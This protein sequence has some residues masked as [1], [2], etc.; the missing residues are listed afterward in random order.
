MEK[1]VGFNS[2][3]YEIVHKYVH[4]HDKLKVFNKVCPKRRNVP[5]KC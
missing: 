2:E 4:I 1:L 3:I 5:I